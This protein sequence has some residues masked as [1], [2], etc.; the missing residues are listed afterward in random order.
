VR[1]HAIE[2]LA[3]VITIVSAL[4]SSHLLAQTPGDAEDGAAIA[5]RACVACH[6]PSGISPMPNTPRLAGQHATYLIKQIRDYRDG[7]RTNEVMENFIRD[8]SDEEIKLVAAY[9]A[10][11]SPISGVITDP[12]LLTL[13]RAVY[14]DGNPG[15]GI[16]ACS[17]CH[18][19]EAE[20]TRRFPMLAGQDVGY[21]IEQMRLYATGKRTN[22][23]GLMQTVA[24]R[25]SE[26]ETL[27]VAQ[28]VAS[29][30]APRAEED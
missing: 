13:G 17:G 20:G 3:I 14:V 1:S 9:Y 16:P 6:A 19:D 12:S 10:E 22:D 30:M 29:L 7:R 24:D 5:A 4:S 18:G 26:A 27:A 21:T 25:M 8:L 2:S 11:Q 15:R 28:Y 23:R